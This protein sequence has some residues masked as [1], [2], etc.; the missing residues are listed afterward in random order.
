MTKPFVGIVIL[1]WNNAKDTLACIKSVQAMEYTPFR[2][3]VVDNGST[4]GS[5]SIIRA[6]FPEIKILELLDNAGYA[7]GNNHG[8]QYALD[9]GAKYILL[10]NNDTLVERSLLSE[11]VEVAEDHPDAGMVGPMM[12]C[13]EP[14]SLLFAAGSFINWS[15]GHMWHRGMFQPVNE[16]SESSSIEVVDFIA[17][18]GVLVSRAL[19]AEVGVLDTRYFLNVEDVEWCVRAQ[20]KGFQIL[21]APRAI[22]YHKISATLGQASVA[23]TYYTTRNSLAFFWQ[24]SPRGL[25]LPAVLRILLRTTRTVIAWKVKPEYRSG[26]FLTKAKANLLGIRDFFR[27]QYGEMPA[28]VLELCGRRV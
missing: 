5:V 20:R 1:N 25:R 14:K 10:L 3:Y 9:D 13:M 24:N 22:L 21:F 7:V 6:E 15:K 26:Q 8:I 23:S 11:L 4:D 12:C 28:D 16:Y 27:G 18:C 17:G 19:I 2:I